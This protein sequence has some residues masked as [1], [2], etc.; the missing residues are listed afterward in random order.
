M[1]ALDQ[2]IS[3]GKNLSQKEAPME[4]MAEE[5]DISFCEG[6]ASYGHCFI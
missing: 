4:A 3:G 5:A 1:E 6:T 2:R